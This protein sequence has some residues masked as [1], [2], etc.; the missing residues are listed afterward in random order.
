MATCGG[1]EVRIALSPVEDAGAGWAD[2]RG[3]QE[4]E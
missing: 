2:S 1:A 4:S 3:P